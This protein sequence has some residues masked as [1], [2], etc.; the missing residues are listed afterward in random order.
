M[1]WTTFFQPSLMF[2]KAVSFF[3]RTK[4][5]WTRRRRVPFSTLERMN[6]TT[7]STLR[8][9]TSNAVHKAAFGT[10]AARKIMRVGRPQCGPNAFCYFFATPP[11]QSLD[12]PL[13]KRI[14]V[15][16]LQRLAAL[17][18]GSL[19]LKKSMSPRWD[20][21]SCMQRKNPTFRPD[22]CWMARHLRV[23]ARVRALKR[24]G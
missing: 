12:E 15:K 1:F 14:N 8:L 2:L 4:P 21:G 16:L 3:G 5:E 11:D 19:L 17:G 18:G 24:L 7:V 20:S 22:T 23:S 10:R 13:S 9:R 6:V